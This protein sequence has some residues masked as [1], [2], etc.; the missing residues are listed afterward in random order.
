MSWGIQWLGLCASTVRGPGSISGWRTKIP[1]A[2]QAAK[3][4]KK[5]FMCLCAFQIDYWGSV[6]F[7][8]SWHVSLIFF[9]F[10]SFFF[11][12]FLVVFHWCFCILRRKHLLKPFLAT[13]SGAFFLMKVVYYL[14]LSL[15]LPTPAL[16]FLLPLMGKFLSFSVSLIRQPTRLPLGNLSLDS[17]KVALE[18]Q[19]AAPSP[20]VGDRF[21]E[22]APC[23]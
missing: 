7:C 3:K 10:F 18:L 21:A 9:F 8:L 20:R 17:Q 23:L 6:T 11:F 2:E 22:P 1:E 14:G 5:K 19:I 16:R 15:S 13:F 12:F 4:G